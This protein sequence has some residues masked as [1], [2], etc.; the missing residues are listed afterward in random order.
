MQEMFSHSK[1]VRLAASAVVA[2]VVFAA[3]P[4]SSAFAY[5]PADGREVLG[6]GAH[7]DAVYPEIENGVLEVSTLTPDGVRSPDEVVL[8]I[9]STDS[10]HVELPAGYEFLGPEGTEAWATTEVQDPTVVWPGWSFEGIPNGI[11]KGT[12]KIS[13]DGFSYAGEGGQPRFAV[14]QPGGFDGSKVTP[15]IVPG[16]TFTSV[17]GEVGGHTHAT[18]TFTEE[19]TYDI[20]LTVAATLAD[21]TALTD[22]ATVRFVVGELGETASEPVAQQDPAVTDTIDALTIVP[23]KVDAEYF[24]GQTVN[25]SALSPD[26]AETDTYRWYT[27]SAGETEPVLDEKQSTSA[28]TTKP[29]R[30]IDGA[31]VYVER[32]AADG[33][34]VETSDPIT[35]GVGQMTQ[36]TALSVTG[37]QD[38]YQVGEVAKFGSAQN[39]QTEDEHYH[40]YLKLAGEDSYEWVPESRLAAQELEITAELQG[41]TLTTRLF[42]ADHSILSEAPTV[43]IVVDGVEGVIEPLD[44]SAD[45]GEYAPGDEATFTANTVDADATVEWSVRLSGENGFEPLDGANGATLTQEIGKDWEGAEVRAVVTEGGQP[46]AEGSVAAIQFASDDASS[47]ADAV[48]TDD[49]G[50]LTV[51][52][53]VSIV[54]AILLLALIV[55]LVLRRRRATDGK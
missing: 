9:P 18:W 27:T 49:A 47:G 45:Q 8:H 33:T 55:L 34:V 3:L 5:D 32:V 50:V 36:T 38:T 22:D 46:A 20:D 31:E 1:R 40:W 24:V 14:T 10:S 23:S 52:I 43:R 28:F 13:Y 30:G 44:V 29:V 53:V 19:G 26:A 17:S 11:L 12:V 16:T 41:A 2:G 54:A 35:I 37:L 21:G 7:V 48:Q 39:P 51:V 6:A 15:L 4:V 25:L 42:N